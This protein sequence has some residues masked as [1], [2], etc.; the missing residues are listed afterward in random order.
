VWRSLPPAQR[1]HAV[2][3][4]ADYGEA[5]AIDEL[6]TGLPQAVSGHNTYWWWGPGN[7]AATTVVAVAPG[8]MDV[9]NYA[10]YLRQYFTTVRVAATLTNPDGVQDQEFGGHVYVCTGPKQ[11][12]GQIWPQ[13]RHY[14]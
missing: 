11:P 6:G 4:T 7:P 5:G 2:I 12:W 1:A 9:T 14:D 8:P 13:L 3:F 10:G